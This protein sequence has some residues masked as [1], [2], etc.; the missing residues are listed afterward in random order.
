M[1][2]LQ[3]LSGAAHSTQEKLIPVASCDTRISFIWSQL[4]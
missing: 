4:L 1:N 3:P 2:F